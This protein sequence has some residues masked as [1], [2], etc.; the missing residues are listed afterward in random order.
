MAIAD[1][2]PQMLAQ[3]SEQVRSIIHLPAWHV[4]SAAEGAGAEA[5][6]Y[7]SQIA[8]STSLSGLLAH[9][10]NTGAPAQWIADEGEPPAEFSVF[11]SD[12][13]A[14]PGNLAPAWALWDRAN[15]ALLPGGNSNPPLPGEAAPQ[16]RYTGLA[17]ADVTA[18]DVST[19]IA[20]GRGWLTNRPGLWLTLSVVDKDGNVWWMGESLAGSNAMT[21]RIEYGDLGGEP[22]GLAVWQNGKPL[23]ARQS[24]ASDGAWTLTTPSPARQQDCRRCDPGRRRLRPHCAATHSRQSRFYRADQRGHAIALPRLQRRRTS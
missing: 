18:A 6:I 8:A 23:Y 11:A 17:V 5:I 4:Q 12:S 10:R 3:E 24:S 15:R 1:P 9:V 16:P 20:I 22:A 19:A 7:S 13:V 21:V 14:A 2:A